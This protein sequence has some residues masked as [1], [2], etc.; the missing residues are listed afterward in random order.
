[1]YDGGRTMG[2]RTRFGWSG[3]GSVGGAFKSVFFSIS[4]GTRQDRLDERNE[5][6]GVVGH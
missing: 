1:M 2:Y 5:Y 6:E 4:Y 3:T